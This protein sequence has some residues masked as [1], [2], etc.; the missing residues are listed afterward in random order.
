LRAPYIGLLILTSPEG[1]LTKCIH[2]GAALPEVGDC[3]RCSA[4]RN[5]SLPPLLRQELNLDRRR[6]RAPAFVEPV[7]EPEH[8]AEPELETAPEQT[9]ASIAIASRPAALWK[10]VAAFSIDAL[11]VTAIL[12]LYL[13]LAAL[14]AGITAP[15]T[16]LTGLDAV[17]ARAHALR[18]VLPA[19]SVLTVLVALSYCAA[20][21][22]LQGGH[23]LGRRSMGIRL[24]DDRGEPP[25][26]GRALTRALIAAASFAFGL[27]GFWLALFDRDGQALHDKLTR[28]FVVQR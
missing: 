21:A 25:T 17:I 7:P 28:T 22:F 3:A 6:D 16:Q 2:C 9:P 1:L 5:P 19:A 24:V 15:P 20:F 10:R 26:P 27:A 12:A 8:A 14:V 4:N 18:P 13:A 11:A 23:T